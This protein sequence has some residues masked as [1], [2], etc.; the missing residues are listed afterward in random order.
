MRNDLEGFEDN[1]NKIEENE[2]EI[3]DEENQF[4]FSIGMDDKK[5][6]PVYQ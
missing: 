3:E 1:E 5:T 2:N 4:T 6:R